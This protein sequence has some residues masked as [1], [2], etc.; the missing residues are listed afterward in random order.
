MSE[1][2]VLIGKIKG[3]DRFVLYQCFFLSESEYCIND[4]HNQYLWIKTFIKDILFICVYDYMTY[5]ILK[6][7][8]TIKLQSLTFN[9]DICLNDCALFTELKKNHITDPDN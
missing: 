6:L 1:S 7:K 8:K 5:F 3:T 4:F 2:E 9:G